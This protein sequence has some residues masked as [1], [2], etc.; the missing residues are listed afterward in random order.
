MKPSLFQSLEAQGRQE[1]PCSNGEGKSA[2]LHL[3]PTLCL[4][5]SFKGGTISG[6]PLNRRSSKVFSELWE[7]YAYFAKEGALGLVSTT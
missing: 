6:V 4:D 2:H 1:D 5:A 3:D 7:S